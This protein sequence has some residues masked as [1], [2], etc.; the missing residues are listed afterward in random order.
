MRKFVPKETEKSMW[1]RRIQRPGGAWVFQPVRAITQPLLVMDELDKPKAVRDAAG[2][3]LQVDV[4]ISTED[5]DEDVEIVP[6]VLITSSATPTTFLLEYRRRSIVFDTRAVEDDLP[7]NRSRSAR[8]FLDA[9]P[10]WDIDQLVPPVW[11]LAPS[12]TPSTPRSIQGLNED[13]RRLYDEGTLAL[14][15][16][17]RAA[18]AGLGLEEAV[19]AV[20]ADYLDTADTVDETLRPV[21]TNLALPDAFARPLADEHRARDDAE[22]RR[23][24]RLDTLALEAR[25]GEL[26]ADL[27]F[28]EQLS[29]DRPRR[30]QVDLA[31]QWVEDVETDDELDDLIGDLD[32]L[33]E[34]APIISAEIENE[35]TNWW[36]PSCQRLVDDE[37][38]A[39]AVCGE[40]E[41]IRPGTTWEVLS[42]RYSPIEGV[43]VLP[44]HDRRRRCSAP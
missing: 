41:Q 26:L 31:R 5:I 42:A 7:V 33:R 9:L 18:W 12:Q 14:L 43:L 37:E 6:V 34:A 13:G 27:A 19:Q 44:R 25:K 29:S 28:A 16:L 11:P 15:L 1:G 23:R 22:R 8:D 32:E 17:G 3:S 40:A 10:R 36:C 21:A 4:L 38:E 20:V 2:N 30:C 39:C 35:R 24:A